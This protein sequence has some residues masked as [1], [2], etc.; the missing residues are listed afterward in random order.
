MKNFTVLAILFLLLTGF[1]ITYAQ[2]W[3]Q[4]YSGSGTS[5]DHANSI[6][7]DASGNVYVTGYENSGASYDYITIKYNLSGVQQWSKRYNGPGNSTDQANSIAVDGSG[8]VY[9]TGI[10][11]E[12][13]TQN[14]Y[15]TIK[16]NSSGVQQWVKFYNG[17]GND[18]DQATSITLD[19]SGNVYVT[20]YSRG[21]GTDYDYATLKYNSSGVLQWI[22]R[23]NGPYSSTD[24]AKLLIVDDSGN[25]Y[26]TGYSKGNTSNNDYATIKYNSN[27]DSLWV[28]R[29]NGPA[30]SL[31]RPNS[32]AV[33]GLGNVYVTGYSFNINGN[34]NDYTTIKY[35]SNGDSL[36]V[37]RY[38]GPGNSGLSADVANSIAID[39]LGHVYV[40]GISTGEG[41]GQDYATI[42]YNSNGDSLWVKRYAGPGSST[43]QAISLKV[44]NLGNVYVTG[45]GTG[46][47]SNFDYVTIKYNSNGDSLWVQKY[48]GTGN[49]NDYVTSLALDNSGN[50]YVTGYSYGT[51]SY[52]I[53]TVKYKPNPPVYLNLT[54][55]VEGFYDDITNSMVTDTMRVYLRNANSPF[56]I[57]DSSKAVLN[58]NGNG[59]YI[60]SNALNNTQYYIV[61]KH[62]NSNET[63]SKNAELVNSNQLNYDFTLSANKAFGDNLILKGTKYCI[64]SGDINQDGSIDVSD[65]ILVYNSANNNGFGY[66]KTDLNGDYFV[67]VTDLLIAYNNSINII[68]IIRP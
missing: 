46:N 34:D 22:K 18:D 10:S 7:V 60:F 37:K 57:V 29:Y 38:G 44:D 8:N 17:P 27:G 42:K 26:V 36:W 66:I 50:I 30:N 49:Q 53:A 28:Q 35:N 4:R 21:N 48:N 3:I 6:A 31:D 67:D 55:L 59:N 47:Y 39:N 11:Y 1:D 14:N 24:Q 64:Y 23:Y 2:E 63:W 56:M 20:G 65:V 68:S 32:I 15:A 5:N 54:S 25:V 45:T 19:S 40:T 51:N 62:R 61:V 16:Y 12:S 9:V 43:D 33:D 52:D 13:A 58:S 41:T